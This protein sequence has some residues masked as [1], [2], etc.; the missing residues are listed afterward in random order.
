KAREFGHV[1]RFIELAGLV[2]RRMP[3]YVVQRT[4]EALNEAGKPLKGARI[5]LLG[6]AYK[7]DVDDVRETPAAEIAELFFERGCK[8]SYH[9]PH[10]PAFPSMRK[11]QIP[12]KSTTLTPAALKRADAVVVVTHHAA[13]DYGLVGRY[14]KLVVDS[15]NAM[16]RVKKARARI[17]KA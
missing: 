14:A 15:R 16:A 8:V 12:L 3:H 10:V 6:I 7:P 9:D 11:H 17:V 4:A 1:T 2:N 5:M 13:V